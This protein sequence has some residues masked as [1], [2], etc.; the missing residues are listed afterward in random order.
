MAKLD[1][2]KIKYR[3][4]YSVDYSAENTYSTADVVSSWQTSLWPC[5]GKYH[6]TKM[7]NLPLHYLEWVGMNFDVNS[8]GYKLVVQ[9]L[10]CRT[11][12]T[13]G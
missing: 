9:E 11:N 5:K 10:E 12:R 4:Q 8:K 7:K 3:P 2:Q 6:G 1:W 13:Q